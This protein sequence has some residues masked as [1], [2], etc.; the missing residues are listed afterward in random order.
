MI[1]IET[2]EC[3]PLQDFGSQSSS[4]GGHA[5]LEISSVVNFRCFVS[6]GVSLVVTKC[7]LLWRCREFSLPSRLLTELVLI[8]R[9]RSDKR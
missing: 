5:I 8:Q 3:F 6:S 7:D 4:W 2:T 9:L 1:L